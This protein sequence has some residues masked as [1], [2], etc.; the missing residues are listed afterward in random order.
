MIE[1]DRVLWPVLKLINESYERAFSQYPRFPKF[2]FTRAMTV[3]WITKT[4][5][6]LKAELTSAFKEV[7]HNDR[8]EVIETL[9]REAKV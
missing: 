3:L 6:K 8:K 9:K 2:S 7:L 1:L 5:N 4:Y